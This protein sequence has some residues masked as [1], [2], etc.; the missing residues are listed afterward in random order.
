MSAVPNMSV[1]CRSSVTRNS[2]QTY[3]IRIVYTGYLMKSA[4][5]GASGGAG[6]G[7][8]P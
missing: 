2:A 4:L 8:L 7:E 5:P 1:I 6:A 3:S